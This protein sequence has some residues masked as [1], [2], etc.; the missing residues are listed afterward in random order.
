MVVF[1]LLFLAT[2]C[3]STRGVAPNAGGEIYFDKIRDWQK[4]INR[5]GWSS[6]RVEELLGHAL[7]FVTY[8]MEL[9]DH[10]DTP[11][12]F[13]GRGFQGDCEDIAIFM[14]GTLKRVGYPHGVRVLA[15]QGWF[16]GHAVLK[17]ELPDGTWRIYDTVTLS[18]RV[19][20]PKRLKPLVEFDEKMIVRLFD[21]Q[22]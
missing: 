19:L 1:A 14:M 20:N 8:R 7:R 13:I 3:E 21:R 18:L 11:S 5:E 16:S 6:E 17:V 9:D 4:R 12:E 22:G 10:W 2:G 15:M